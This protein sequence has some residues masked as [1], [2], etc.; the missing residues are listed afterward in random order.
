MGSEWV[1]TTTAR[2]CCH[3][4][5]YRHYRRSPFLYGALTGRSLVRARYIFGIGAAGMEDIPG[6]LAIRF[7]PGVR[8]L[9]QESVNAH[10]EALK[11]TFANAAL[12]KSAKIKDAFEK[13]LPTLN[14]IIGRHT[15]ITGT[16]SARAQEQIVL[17]LLENLY[18]INI[19]DYKDLKKILAA[20][21]A[22]IGQA[23]LKFQKVIEFVVSVKAS[24]YKAAYNLDQAKRSAGK[25]AVYVAVLNETF[26]CNR[27]YMMCDH[28]IAQLAFDARELLLGVLP[29]ERVRT[30]SLREV[31]RVVGAQ[32][33]HEVLAQIRTK[34]HNGAVSLDQKINE[35]EMIKGLMRHKRPVYD[36]KYNLNNWTETVLQLLS[37]VDHEQ[38]TD[39]QKQ[40]AVR[41]LDWCIEQRYAAASRETADRHREVARFI[42]KRWKQIKEAVRPPARADG[43]AKAENVEA[44]IEEALET[45]PEA[46]PVFCELVMPLPT[47]LSVAETEAPPE[48]ARALLKSLYYLRELCA[49]F[50]ILSAVMYGV[51]WVHSVVEDPFSLI[52]EVVALFGS[53]GH[54]QWMG[55]MFAGVVMAYSNVKVL[56]LAPLIVDRSRNRQLAL[57]LGVSGVLGISLWGV[58]SPGLYLICLQLLAY[59]ASAISF[60]TG[61]LVL[62]GKK[63]LE[64]LLGG[65]KGFWII[66][67]TTVLAGVV[68]LL[69]SEP[70][71]FSDDEELGVDLG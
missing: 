28:E 8:E 29:Y 31:L 65:P 52:M 57:L 5:R 36:Q 69:C 51:W 10:A 16:D 47:D 66:A 45:F 70:Y 40:A 3:R 30:P 63:K 17:D 22:D 24:L 62:A 15:E 23:L 1:V 2:R 50:F 21:D 60:I 26:Q 4:R 39:G 54:V 35:F 37:L 11:Q 18:I 58:L 25:P 12:S 6:K 43:A 61:C 27:A 42:K 9:V 13:I 34:L 38:L 41:H 56:S 48:R 55:L 46:V 14:R 71:R 64:P 32:E 33:L 44:A 59:S 7:V 49:V 19:L 67:L 20:K 68:G 53:A